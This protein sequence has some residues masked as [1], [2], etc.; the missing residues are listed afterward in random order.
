MKQKQAYAFRG[1]AGSFVRPARLP[2]ELSLNAG[3]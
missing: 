2:G 1:G 3:R